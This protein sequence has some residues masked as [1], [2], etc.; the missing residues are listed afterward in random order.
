MSQ[1][2][3]IVSDRPIIMIGPGGLLLAVPHLFDVSS[4]GFMDG[5]V[6]EYI[7][8]LGGEKYFRSDIYCTARD[9]RSREE[10]L[11]QKPHCMEKLTAILSLF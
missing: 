8:K 2:L 6:K 10:Y 4:F 1:L 7:T 3:P 9:A 11:D 5:V